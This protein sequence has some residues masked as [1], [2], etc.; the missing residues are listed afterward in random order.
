MSF[1][2]KRNTA[3]KDL[4]V[5]MEI[6]EGRLSPHFVS[7]MCHP[8]SP[9]YLLKGGLQERL[10]EAFRRVEIYITADLRRNPHETPDTH[11]PSF[12]S[13]ACAL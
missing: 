6:G 9:R 7:G 8:C 1:A 13:A 3:E 2:L 4:A 11:I 12:F 5:T 10:F